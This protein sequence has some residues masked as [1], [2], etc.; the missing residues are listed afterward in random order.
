MFTP[1][2]F[3]RVEYYTIN[4]LLNLQQVNGLLENII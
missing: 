2:D 3:L 1:R 4:Y